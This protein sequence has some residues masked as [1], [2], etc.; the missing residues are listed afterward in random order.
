[1]QPLHG[2]MVRQ[3]DDRPAALG[4]RPM[5]HAELIGAVRLCDA[6]L[7]A[8]YGDDILASRA[9]DAQLR[10]LMRVELRDELPVLIDG[11]ELRLPARQKPH[12]QARGGQRRKNKDPCSLLHD[13]IT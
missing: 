9:A 12:E 10:V 11:G 5:Q 8:G 1:M 4:E 13:A 2:Q 7:A 6:D 3:A